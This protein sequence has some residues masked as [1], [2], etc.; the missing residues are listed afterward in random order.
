[1]TRYTNADFADDDSVN[2]VQLNEGISSS[3]THIRYHAG[4]TIWKLRSPLEKVL[5][6][7]VGILLFVIFI[8]AII[9]HVTEHRLEENKVIF[10]LFSL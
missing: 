6:I 1:M 5:L 4:S 7:L 10:V 2:S 9:L 8:L 3:T